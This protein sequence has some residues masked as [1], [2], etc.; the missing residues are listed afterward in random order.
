M[1]LPPGP[2]TDCPGAG[3][4]QRRHAVGRRRG[5]AE[6]ADD[7]AASLHLLR[8]DQLGRFDDAGPCLLQGRAL[9]Q[10]GAGDRGTDAE[11]VGRFPDLAQA[12]DRL[13]VD[14]Q[15][16][17]DKAALHPHQEVAASGHDERILL[18][19]GHKANC[20]FLASS[21][22]RT[23]FAYSIPNVAF[24]L[25]GPSRRALDGHRHEP[26]RNN[27]K[28]RPLIAVHCIGSRRGWLWEG[29]RNRSSEPRREFRRRGCWVGLASKIATS[30]TAS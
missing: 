2:T 27:D 25:L 23:A 8:A 5:V 1:R 28:A 3:R 11:A 16:G 18:G 15:V 13:D 7:G 22:A 19:L 20:F 10:H 14:D 9:S 6:I 17:F 12:V 26:G 29:Q 24:N 21:G 30:A 4:D